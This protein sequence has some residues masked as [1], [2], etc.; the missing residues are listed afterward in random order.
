MGSPIYPSSEQIDRLFAAS[1][2]S[3]E[4]VD[5]EGNAISLVLPPHGVAAMLI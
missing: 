1:E 3:R 5:I 4:T 2:V